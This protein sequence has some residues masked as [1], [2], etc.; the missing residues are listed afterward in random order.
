[1]TSRLALL[2]S[3]CLAAPAMAQNLKPL[4]TPDLSG[5]SADQNAGLREA[6]AN[7]DRVSKTVSGVELAELYG[8]MGGFYA[9][10]RMPEV[11]LVAFENAGQIV[12]KD[13]RWI[14][15]QGVML[16][17]TGK[18]E[19]AQKRF[20]EAFKLNPSYLPT[21]LSIVA[22]RMR[23]GDFA[24]AKKLLEDSITTNPNQPAPQAMLGEIAFRE[25]RYADAS[26]HVH[27][28]LL[29]DPRATSL[30]GALARAEQ[31]AGN[32]DAA[33]I[34]QVKSGDVP[35]RLDDPLLERIMPSGAAPAPA[36]AAAA[37]NPNEAVL[38][39]VA[40]QLATGKPDLARKALDAALKRTPKDPLLLA[41]Y[42]RVEA[43]AD[44]MDAA[45]SRAREAVAADPK[46]QPAW[47][48]QGIILEMAGDD[49]GA[50]ESYQRAIA[51]D[52][53]ST[54]PHV[55]AGNLAMRTG[56]AADAVTAYRAVVGAS[57]DDVDGWARLLA[58]EF[59]AG[60]CQAGVKESADN[61][62]RAPRNPQ[63]AELAIR[64][65]STCRAA[66][67]AQRQQALVDAEKLYKGVQSDVAQVGEAYALALAAN[68]KWE[69]AAQTQGG[70]LFEAVR[71]GDPDAIAQ[72][73]E[74]YQRFE[75]KQLPD[76]PWA[77][78]HALLKPQRPAAAPPAP[79]PA[80]ATPAGR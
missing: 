49:A 77:S 7:F 47:I 18:A 54:R 44:R 75:A 46:S 52:T 23:K 8:D 79:A 22:E 66:T 1:M 62:K 10:A 37:A 26:R 64:A 33:K 78:T 56:R 72:Y 25:K 53:R 63:F 67:P 60:Q 28:A 27:A 73:R 39:E 76:M 9:R 30:Y 43:S 71:V 41:S 58:A 74:L 50:R 65:A 5:L 57:Q 61:A 48:T 31:A 36:A 35:P 24:G 59:V 40:L 45:K 51:V 32:P 15:L 4:P 69:D 17:S 3:L 70:A 42:A 55:L 21:R 34:A 38:G 19:E 80:A 13:D 11:A 2:L 68:G 20:D 14:Y 6:R 16:R 12:P 29:L